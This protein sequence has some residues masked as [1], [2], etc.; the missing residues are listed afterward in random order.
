MEAWKKVD[1]SSFYRHTD[2]KSRDRVFN[3]IV[4]R[5]ERNGHPWKKSD[6]VVWGGSIYVIWDWAMILVFIYFLW[7]MFNFFQKRYGDVQAIAFLLIMVL[8]RLNILIRKVGSI[9]P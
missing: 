5:Y 7:F 3:W 4:R 6:E 8:F 9:A 2:F 1:N